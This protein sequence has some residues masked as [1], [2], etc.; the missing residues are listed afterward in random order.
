MTKTVANLKVLAFYAQ[1]VGDGES[2]MASSF[3]EYHFR[4]AGMKAKSFPN[5]YNDYK[6]ATDFFSSVRPCRVPRVKGAH[7]GGYVK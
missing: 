2:P 6:G 3:C 1:R 5:A 7:I 4:A